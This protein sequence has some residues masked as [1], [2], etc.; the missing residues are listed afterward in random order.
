MEQYDEQ[1]GGFSGA[2]KFPLSLQLMHLLERKEHLEKVFHTLKKMGNGGIYDHLGGGFSRYSV[3]ESWIVPHFEKMLY[4]NALLLQA[5]AKAYCFSNDEFFKEK[6]DGVFDYVKHVLLQKNGFASGQDAD[7]EGEEGRYYVFTK[8]EIERHTYYPELF[9][10]YFSIEDYGNFEGK[11]VLFVKEGITFSQEQKKQ[12]EE[13]KNRLRAYRSKRK[14]PAIDT[15]IIIS[16]N[17]LMVS[18]LVAYGRY[19]RSEDA[20]T[21]ARK[22]LDCILE[23]CYY[24]GKLLRISGKTDL[25]G[26]LEDYSFLIHALLDFYELSFDENYL[27]KSKEIAKKAIEL[28]YN[29]GFSE[30]SELHEPLYADVY[31]A[32]DNVMPSGVSMMIKALFRLNLI[33]HSTEYE[34]MIKYELERNMGLM[35]K[36]PVQY[37]VL[38]DALAGLQGDFY[39][40]EISGGEKFVQKMHDAILQIPVFNMQIFLGKSEKDEIKICFKQ[41]CSVFGNFDELKKFFEAK[42]R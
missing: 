34:Q 39:A 2:P 22:V 33:E 17:A 32:Q 8:E 19:C 28:F 37:P 10:N 6:A 40:V 29:D 41:T 18:G 26:F 15:K 42:V 21:L 14:A 5:Y 7:S 27:V 16:W 36:I 24:G 20:L 30:R 13:D 12:I 31:S 9:C 35:K 3:D 11:N 25:P 4:D 38:L 23:D 1:H